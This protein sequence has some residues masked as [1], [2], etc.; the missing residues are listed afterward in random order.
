MSNQHYFK[1]SSS[2]ASCD[3]NDETKC[4]II[5]F[6]SGSSHRYPNCPKSEFEALKGATSP[7]KHFHANVR[8]K[9]KS[10][11]I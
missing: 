6:V 9:Y 11:R 10:E 4:M 5:H 2:I 1:G 3:Y 7:G 8:N